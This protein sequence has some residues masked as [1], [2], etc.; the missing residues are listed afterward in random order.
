[1]NPPA[2]PW[3]FLNGVYIAVDAIEGAY[4]IV[5]G[6]YC[7]FTKAEIQYCHNLRC[8]LLPQLGH[9]RIVHTG[10]GPAREEVQSLS[11][12][13]TARVAGIFARIC[14]RP[15]AQVVLATSFDFNELQGFPL[16]EIARRQAQSSRVPVCHVPSR[17]LG[18]DWLD[19]YALAC[20]ALARG[21]PL[22]S[23][24]RE[25]DSVAVVGYLQD[26]D[27]PDHVGNR[28]ELRRL[29][30]ALGL[31]TVSI[32][33]SGGGRRELEAAARAS[34]I[35]SLPYA[36]KAARILSRRLHIRLCE[37]ELPLGLVATERFLLEIARSVGRAA[38][39][40]RVIA[41]EGA[42]AIRD[43]Q[44]HVLRFIT[45]REAE[46]KQE[47]AQLQ[48]RLSELCGELGMRVVEP[49]TE[50][51]DRCRVYLTHTGYDFRADAAHV[52]IGYP[53][54]V[55]HPVREMPYLGYA[56]IRCLVDRIGTALL[57]AEA[58]S[59]RRQN[60]AAEK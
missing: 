11:T 58:G 15:D 2:Q 9:R 38:Q 21:I 26:R 6:P 42:A 20:E 43:T 36:R 12:D 52:P 40:K 7:T 19:G 17:S 44:S 51:Q 8:R 39:A 56:G 48:A 27:E 16:R 5:D 3:P 22:E 46:V 33:L 31:R 57:R 41:R 35:V 4:L 30:A 1:M 24:Q 55:E 23:G 60:A 25:R 50:R 14:S 37:T 49:G 13:R 54:Y 28:R 32:W 34:L 59:G 10:R 18:G 47:D 53:N 45:G 29:L